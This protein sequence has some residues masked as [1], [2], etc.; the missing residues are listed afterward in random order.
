MNFEKVAVEI[1]DRVGVLRLNEPATL[2]ALSLQMVEDL[3]QA[4]D[5]LCKSVRALVLTG[6]GRGFC[7]GAALDGRLGSGLLAE[8]S[9]RDAGAVLASHINPL[10]TRLRDLPIPW[11]TAVGGAAAGVGASL[12]LAGDLVFAGESAYFLQAFARIGLVPDGGSTHMLVR[13][14]GRV[15][16]MEL[17][18][19]AERLPAAKA[20]EWGLVNRV[21]AD[22][23]L[24]EEALAVATRLANGPSLAL[25]LIRRSVWHAVDAT[26][27]EALNMEREL[28]LTAGRSAD[29]DEGVAAFQAKRPASFNGN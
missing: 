19:L 28:Q 20:M 1:H 12:A 2:N 13:T 23:R 25:G 16:A 7:S 27:A 11:L 17:A 21:V 3:N 22:V 26:W 14:I 4:L 8:R 18:L 15:R 10:M 29:F 24:E 6:A 5:A 9:Q